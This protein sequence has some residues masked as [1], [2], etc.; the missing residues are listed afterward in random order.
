MAINFKRSELI[1]RII[2]S[3]MVLLIAGISILFGGKLF[4]WTLIIL[5]SVIIWELIGFDHSRNNIRIFGTSFFTL[6][7]FFIFS[8]YYLLALSIYLLWIFIYI[9]VI[10]PKDIIWRILYTIIILCGLISIF[11]LRINI[12]LNETIWVI[13]CVIS[14]D[15][16]GYFIGRTIGGP[17]L[18]PKVSPNKTWSGTLGGW[19]LAALVTLIF[20][21]ITNEILYINIFWAVMIAIFAQLGDLAESAL[22]RKAGIK[23]SSNL[24][25]GHGGFLDRFDGMIGAF[26][27]LF[28]LSILN[29]QHWMF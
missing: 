25:P 27:L 26:F 19:G 8:N 10:K 29:I 13:S 23:D 24:I 4:E 18:W 3:V 17:K 15:I 5:G 28:I 16:G 22:K 11:D 9:F 20:I 6:S 14:A 12:G 1:T 21:N 2:S 7:L